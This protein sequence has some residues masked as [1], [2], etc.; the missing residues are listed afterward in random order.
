MI[1]WDRV[2]R[3]FDNGIEQVM[4]VSKVVS[5]RARVEAAVARL[6]I[7]KGSIESKGDRILKQLGERVFFLW[8]QKSGGVMNDQDVLEAVRGLSDIKI[9][10]ESLNVK[11]KKASIGEEE[12]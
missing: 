12:I 2:K 8:E 1:L 4:R 5:E 3:S 11:I 10:I 7:E 6:L 9:E